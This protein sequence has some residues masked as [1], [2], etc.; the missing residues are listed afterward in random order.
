MADDKHVYEPLY[1]VRN[2]KYEGKSVCTKCSLS[3]HCFCFQNVEF[4]G[5]YFFVCLFVAINWKSKTVSLSSHYNI[6][7]VPQTHQFCSY[8]TQVEGN[9]W[10]ELF[11]HFNNASTIVVNEWCQIAHLLCPMLEISSIPYLH[12]QVVCTYNVYLLAYK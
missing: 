4:S 10:K 11:P 8:H 2:W 5:I 9:F 3:C 1:S 6:A 12:G 7:F